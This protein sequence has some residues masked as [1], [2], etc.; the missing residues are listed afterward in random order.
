MTEPAA[1]FVP[2][3]DLT[4][5]TAELGGEVLASWRSLVDRGAF[6]GGDAVTGFEEAFADYLGSA[7]AV[8][9]ANG[10]DALVVALRALDLA[11]GDEVIVPAFTFIATGS[12]VALAGGTP[13]FADVE[14]D[15]LNLDPD[16]LERRITERTVGVIGVHLFGRPFDVA[17]VG[18]VCRRHGLWWIEDAAQAQG[19][20]AV[21]EGG[22]R[23]KVGNFGTLAC[24]S[25]YPTKNL[26]AFGDA[27]AV[28][29][30][31]PELLARVRR[32]ANHGRTE[33][34]LHGELGTNSRLDALQAAVLS[35]RLPGLDDANRRR[36][37]IACRYHGALDGLDAVDLP[38]DPD[39][40][41]SVYHQFTLLTD[42][43]DDLKAH[44]AAAGIGSGVYYPIPLHRQPA[45]AGF[46]ADDLVLPVSERAAE[47]ALSLPMFPQLR[48][49]EVARVVASLRS[50]FART[51]AR[52][53]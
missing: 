19:A 38:A 28:T 22:E 9:V 15:T 42:R 34:Y 17:R 50:F 51:V 45:L 16:D 32:I 35:H 20:E 33:H 26:G 13:V 7:G 2:P 52:G 5:L 10:T 6:V 46:V 21:A 3:F 27:G 11:P 47:R 18:D 40:A 30:N 36:G 24:W 1:T 8:G 44:L 12:A 23:R 43:R 14:P 41:V 49:D 53:C 29:G 48:D 4:R 39:G 37:E 25:F 31:D